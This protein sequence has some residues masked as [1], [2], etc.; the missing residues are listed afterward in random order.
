MTT[1]AGNTGTEYFF[2][3]YLNY[4]LPHWIYHIIVALLL[5][6]SS[7]RAE[8]VPDTLSTSFIDASLGLYLKD[9]IPFYT[10]DTALT[11]TGFLKEETVEPATDTIDPGHAAWAHFVVEND[12]DTM[13]LLV[14]GTSHRLEVNELYIIDDGKITDTLYTGRY[15]PFNK[16]AVS[17]QN[18]LFL[19]K[20][21]PH[22]TVELVLKSYNISINPGSY[23][24]AYLAHELYYNWF[25]SR[26]D[27]ED[28][29]YY[30]IAISF[31]GAITIMI[32]FMLFLYL[33]NRDE[34]VYIY[35]VFYM[36]SVLL[37]MLLKTAHSGPFY[38]ML[39]DH[40]VLKSALNEP[41]QF[42]LMTLYNLFAIKFL[43]IRKNSP[44]LYKAIVGVNILYMLYA[45]GAFIYVLI[46]KETRS[47]D[48]F[49]M[50]PTRVFVFL[51]GIILIF[52]VYRSIRGPLTRY[53]VAGSSLFLFGSLLGIIY[54]IKKFNSELGD[55]MLW[56][57]DTSL[58]PINFTQ[59]GIIS[60]IILFSLGI[61]KL[62]QLN[63]KEKED[64][65]DAYINQLEE[66]EKLTR[67]YTER[68]ETEVK[69]RTKE[70]VKK[71][72]ELVELKNQKEKLEMEGQIMDHEMR[73]LRL[74]MNPHFIFNSLNSIRFFILKQDEDKAIEYIES[75]S[76]L[77]RM[78]LD[79]S[80]R[81]MISLK[82]ELTALE[83]YIKFEKE[84]FSQKFDYTILI[85]KNLNPESVAIPPLLLQPFVE[86]SIWHGLMQKDGKG[87]LLIDIKKSGENEMTIAIEDNGI[88]RK[89]ASEI[90]AKRGKKH[91]S[92]GMKITQY[93][94]DILN[95][96]KNNY[97]FEVEDLLTPDGKPAG[98]RI[99]FKLK[100]NT[101]E[102][103]DS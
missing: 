100:L 59:L 68:L 56:L 29:T 30:G 24:Y 85:D 102:S 46:T 95:N 21:K 84:R 76:K 71:T 81:D 83:L 19:I 1:F 45:T 62:I 58:S 69:E 47:I 9:T 65:K 98:T 52:W 91:Q 31:Y 20:L 7:A 78:I 17:E 4:F 15:V 55:S 80:R 50:P 34:P 13:H 101:Y 3:S 6:P 2:L 27:R 41:L 86:N 87:T 37:Y 75:F 67:S 18:R 61:G 48:N 72:T 53:F 70:V 32:L 10:S 12:K 39:I 66:N 93:R 99:T 36:T 64:I 16:R 90:A 43:D 63:N 40:P 82:E 96:G 79:Y 74:Q 94:I 25:L 5:L 44:S 14:L 103:A 23:K 8:I 60:E 73:I 89:K 49:L 88:G 77:L 92:H 97:N 51:A 11:I 54:S 28:M 33:Q 42:V 35:Y 57:P 22:Q 26:I 38:F